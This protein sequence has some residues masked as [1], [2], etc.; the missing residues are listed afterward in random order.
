MGSLA[1]PP[2]SVLS[3]ASEAAWYEPGRGAATC[4]S[5]TVLLTPGSAVPNWSLRELENVARD[6]EDEDEGDDEEELEEEL[7]PPLPPAPV[8]PAPDVRPVEAV[9]VMST[10]DA[11]TLCRAKVAEAATEA[12]LSQFRKQHC[13]SFEETEE[14]K[15]E[16]TTLHEQYMALIDAEITNALVERLGPTFSFEAFLAALPAFLACPGVASGDEATDKGGD[17][18][19]DRPA[20]LSHTLDVLLRFTSFEAFKADML[21]AKRA[22]RLEAEAVAEGMA[23]YFSVP[24]QRQ[25]KVCSNPHRAN[26]FGGSTLSA[27]RHIHAAEGLRGLWRGFGSG[28][29]VVVPRRGLK[30]AFNSMF[31]DL[32]EHMPSRRR[33]L[34]SGGLAGALEAVL[35][36]PAEVLKVIMQSERTQRGA[37]TTKLASAWRAVHAAGGLSAWYSGLGATVA[38]HS[39]HSCVYFAS[40][41]EVRRACAPADEST[42]AVVSVVLSAGAGFV[43]GICAGVCNNPFDVLKSRQQVAAAAALRGHEL[44]VDYARVERG[45]LPSL[46]RA[47]GVCILWRGLG[48]KLLRLGPGS[49]II[50]TV[51]EAVLRRLA[52]ARK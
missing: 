25:G 1:S 7:P 47:G 27:L 10:K 48:A 32:F 50:F 13:D 8:P 5:G 17:D 20:S 23:L 52:H 29:A 21:A 35:V 4:M 33:A 44:A 12:E 34:L 41:A 14:N 39:V 19:Y 37:T 24:Q 18:E 28:L 40:F 6:T 46:V 38:K 26:R 30:F 3:C 9:P 2:T 31:T 51:Y 36:T 11:L 43:A 22:K 45:G 42:S 49:A 15:L 16:Y